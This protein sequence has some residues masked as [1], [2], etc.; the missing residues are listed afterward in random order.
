[1]EKTG[2][3]KESENEWTS[4][5]VIVTKKDGGIHICV[6]FRKLNQLTKFDAYPMLRIDD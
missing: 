6:D 3:A 4:P 2:I 1:M 5:M